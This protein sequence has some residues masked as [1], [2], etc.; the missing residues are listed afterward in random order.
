MTTD[1][2]EA[3]R[4]A[5]ADLHL[6]RPVHAVLARGRRLRRRRHAFGIGAGAVALV[7][8][9]GLVSVALPSGSSPLPTAQAGWGP[10]MVNLSESDV[11]EADAH[12]RSGLDGMKPGLPAGLAPLAADTRGGTTVLVYQ[13][14]DLADTCAIGTD[15]GQPGSTFLSSGF[16]W[17]ELIPPGHHYH[18]LTSGGTRPAFPLSELRDGQSPDLPVTDGIEVLRVSDD[19]S[20]LVLHVA[21]QDFEARVGDGIAVSWVPQ[22]IHDSD[23]LAATVTAYDTEDNELESGLLYAPDLRPGL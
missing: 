11:V 12:C 3:L 6:D 4:T 21:G 9:G 2:D 5:G 17:N 13:F 8:A 19:V 1:L 20:R 10:R 15:D 23:I 22:G 18:P 14:D 7:A 16:P